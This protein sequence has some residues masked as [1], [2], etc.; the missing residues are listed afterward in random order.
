MTYL[1]L[2]IVSRTENWMRKS[3]TF[4]VYFAKYSIP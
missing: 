3:P 2:T 1:V 4:G